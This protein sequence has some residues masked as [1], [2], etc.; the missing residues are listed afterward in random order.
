MKYVEIKNCRYSNESNTAVDC[1]VLFE[2]LGWVEFTAGPDDLPY[3]REIF[4]R[5][6]AGDFGAVA[7]YVPIINELGTLPQ[8][9]MI[10][11]Q[12]NAILKNLDQIVSNP[13]RWSVFSQ[14]LQQDY[15]RYRQELLDVPQQ[16]GFPNDVIWPTP[17]NGF[18]AGQTSY[19]ISLFL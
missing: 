14:E 11:N 15:I 16:S 6:V 17:P 4:Y 19:Q 7:P 10:R 3:G 18:D 1:T 8:E 9:T 2:D 12:R 13:L 5:A